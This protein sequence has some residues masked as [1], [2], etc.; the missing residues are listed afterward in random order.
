MALATSVLWLITPRGTSQEVLG[1]HWVRS[2][3]MV[4]D[5]GTEEISNVEMLATMIARLMEKAPAE[6]Q[7][8]AERVSLRTGTRSVARVGT[9]C[10]QCRAIRPDERRAAVCGQSASYA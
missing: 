10:G 5:I 6:S 9:Y 7:D 2:R 1:G 4:M 8:G 3:D